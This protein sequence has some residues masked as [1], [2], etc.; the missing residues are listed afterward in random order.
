MWN[1]EEIKKAFETISKKA[2]TDKSFRELCLKDAA[3][4]IKEATGKDLPDGYKVKFVENQGANATFVLPNFKSNAAELNDNEL[5]AVAGGGNKCGG[6]C[7]G[8][9]ACGISSLF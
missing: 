4:A 7:G 2:M 5:D 9:E 1:Q 3:K 8:S 6:S